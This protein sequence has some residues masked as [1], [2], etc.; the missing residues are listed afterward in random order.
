MI[1]RLY[2]YLR[3]SPSKVH[4]LDLRVETIKKW[5]LY[6]NISII[7][8]FIMY[9]YMRKRQ[10]GVL[11]NGLYFS[12]AMAPPEI[13]TRRWR[14]LKKRCSFSASDRL[15]RS[16]SFTEQDVLKGEQ[17]LSRTEQEERDK[18]LTVGSRDVNKFQGIREKISQWNNDFKKRRSTEN[19]NLQSRVEQGSELSK[20]NH[21]EREDSMFV[22]ACPEQGY[23]KSAL[24]ISS[25]TKESRISPRN[26]TPKKPGLPGV[27]R[28]RQDSSPWST[29]SPS[30]PASDDSSDFSHEN[31]RTD[32]YTSHSALYQ[33]Q[34]SGY[35]GF[36][37]EK[38]IYSTGSSETS[39]LLSS[40]GLEH[41][42]GTHFSD[43]FSKSR[44]RPRPSPI[45]EKHGDYGMRDQSVGHY[46]TITPRA[47]IAQATVINLVKTRSLSPESPPPLPPRPSLLDCPSSL[48]PLPNPKPRSRQILHGAVSLPRKRTDFQ[49][50]A[51]RRE[52]YHDSEH[53]NTRNDDLILE[54][55][56][57][58]KNIY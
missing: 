51:R 16:K 57:K 20:F 10:D 49:D 42:P 56:E 36:C 19:L 55:E 23:V 35:D 45:Y 26:S 21:E 54:P 37:P 14:K 38:S 48:P 2:A 58:V 1:T 40:E 43:P 39:S 47:K 27:R 34:D 3:F 25:N 12:K 17:T 9:P 41:S 29:P 24:V 44:P 4:L 7:P 33:D 52:S 30:P 53:T 8:T 13:L 22:L 6:I 15:V 32:S 31:Q 46:G 5:P 11:I 50:R 18:Y 28:E